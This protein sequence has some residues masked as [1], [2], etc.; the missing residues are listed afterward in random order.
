MYYP[1]A[2]SIDKNLATYAE[3]AEDDTASWL[4]M[5]FSDTDIQVKEVTLV[6]YSTAT[7]VSADNVKLVARL[8]TDAVVYV[9]D[10]SEKKHQCGTVQLNLDDVSA[11]GQ[12]YSF[13]CDVI[14]RQIRVE[15]SEGT[16][17]WAGSYR[18][19]HVIVAECTVSV[20]HSQT[21]KPTHVQIIILA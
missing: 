19:K 21:G 5:I 9:L 6:L 2:L 17:E 15:S 4:L 13:P 11:G 12:T 16:I 18:N 20:V 7:G 10:S 14:G 8:M 1:A 3:A